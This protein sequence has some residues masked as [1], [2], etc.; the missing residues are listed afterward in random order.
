VVIL[1]L[2]IS[3]DQFS[4]H[5]SNFRVI[6]ETLSDHWP[7]SIDVDLSQPQKI[8]KTDWEKFKLDLELSINI[9]TPLS[10]IAEIDNEIQSLTKAIKTAFDSNTKLIQQQHTRVALPAPILHLIALKKNTPESIRKTT[11]MSPN[12]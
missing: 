5:T 6:K 1:D 3:S 2:I 8:K 10:E 11:M 7:V 4:T 12:E 9:S